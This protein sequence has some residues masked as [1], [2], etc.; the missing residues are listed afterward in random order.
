MG[1]SVNDFVERRRKIC[2]ECDRQKIILTIRQCVECGCPIWTKTKVKSTSC[3]LGK[4]GSE[5]EDL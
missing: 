5:P 3:P 1:Q 4:W 2:K